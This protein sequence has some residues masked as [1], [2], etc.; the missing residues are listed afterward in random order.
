[1]SQDSRFPCWEM[2]N[3]NLHLTVIKMPNSYDNGFFG[4][5][6]KVDVQG[7]SLTL[8]SGFSHGNAQV[9]M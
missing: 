4:G 5:C 7:L 3:S 9:T 6:G 1:M 2:Y 8:S